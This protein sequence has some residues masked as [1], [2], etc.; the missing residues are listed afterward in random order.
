MCDVGRFERQDG[1]A[2]FVIEGDYL[3]AGVFDETFERSGLV[4]RFTGFTHPMEEYA[5]ALEE[6]GLLIERLREPRQRDE[7]VAKDP[8]E[9]RWQRVPNFLFIRALKPSGV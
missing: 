7:A 6:A 9:R 4:M 5:R 3:S 8:S 1:D 2:P